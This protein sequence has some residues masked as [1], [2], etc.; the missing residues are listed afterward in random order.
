MTKINLYLI[1]FIHF[2]DNQASRILLKIY[3]GS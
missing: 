3:A 2:K 1:H